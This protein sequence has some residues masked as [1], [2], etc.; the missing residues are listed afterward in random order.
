MLFH[1]GAANVITAPFEG[2][3][4]TVQ[5]EFDPTGLMI[6]N[7]VT[8]ENPSHGCEQEGIFENGLIAPDTTTQGFGS[9][10]TDKG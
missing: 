3:Y 7:P 1:Q 5:T 10:L 9:F 4:C 8:E 2:F 6:G